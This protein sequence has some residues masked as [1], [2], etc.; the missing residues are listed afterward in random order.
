MTPLEFEEMFIALMWE[1][2]MNAD[3]EPNVTPGGEQ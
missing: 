2:D 1:W 3:G